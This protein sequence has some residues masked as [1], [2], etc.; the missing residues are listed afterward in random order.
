MKRWIAI[1]CLFLG[2]VIA[3]SVIAFAY[4][5]TTHTICLG[6]ATPT[7]VDGHI[8][9]PGGVPRQ[10]HGGLQPWPTMTP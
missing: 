8:I 6:T 3:T 7:K 10:I 5:T 9:C 4:S 2:I 1:L